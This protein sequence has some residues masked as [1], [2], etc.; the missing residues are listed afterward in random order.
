MQELCWPR[1]L[2]E[3]KSRHKGEGISRCWVGAEQGVGHG[4]GD[5]PGFL[6]LPVKRARRRCQGF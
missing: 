4:V 5:L 6:L 3:H 1:I 2:A